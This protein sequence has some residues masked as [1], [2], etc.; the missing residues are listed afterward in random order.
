MGVFKNA[1]LFGYFGLVARRVLHDIH[2]HIGGRV[3][4][5][6]SDEFGIVRILN[7]STTGF[8]SNLDTVDYMVVIIYNGNN[9]VLMVH[10]YRC[11]YILADYFHVPYDNRLVFRR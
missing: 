4:L 9:E 6:F 10:P 5:V 11:V 2:T 3:W 7:G 8:W 1:R